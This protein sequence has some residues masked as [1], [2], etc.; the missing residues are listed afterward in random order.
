MHKVRAS[1]LEAVLDEP[2]KRYNPREPQK[3]MNRCLLIVATGIVLAVAPART[4]CAAQ[5]P[6]DKPELIYSEQPATWFED[7]S[8]RASLSHDGKSALYGSGRGVKLIDLATGRADSKR[9]T[10]GLDEVSAAVFYKGDQLAIRG[11]R[12]KETGW[13]VPGK[14]G[15][16]GSS[17]RHYPR[18]RPQL[19]CRRR[20]GPLGTASEPDK[21][22]FIDSSGEQKK[23]ENLGGNITGLVWSTDGSEI[24]VLVYATDGTSS[25]CSTSTATPATSRRSR[26]AIWMP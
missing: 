13:L 9:L 12:G 20:P 26:W 2:H 24:Y 11:R 5:Q 23:Y 1:K 6:A 21:G 4:A 3:N 8:K 18:R 10:A 7:A 14:V 17:F 25:R 22:L 16:A 15:A 19:V